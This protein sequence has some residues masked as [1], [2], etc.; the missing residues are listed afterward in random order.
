MPYLESDS[1]NK[2]FFQEKGEGETILMIHG[3]AFDSS[4]WRKQIDYLSR[5]F[6]VIA[7]DL[8]GHG[9]SQYR[10]G[11][12]ITKELL[13]LINKLKY[14]NL[15]IIGHSFGGVLALKL[16]L[17]SP[18]LI[19]R[20]ILVNTS[21]KFRNTNGLQ[22]GLDEQD[23]YKMKKFLEKEYPKILLVFYRWLFTEEERKSSNF[24]DVWRE[25][26]NKD[27]WPQKEALSFMLSMIEQEDLVD[28]LDNMEIPT[29]TTY[30]THDPICSTRAAE[31]MKQRIKNSTLKC[32]QQS[33]HLPFL[34]HAED[35]N[36]TIGNFL[37]NSNEY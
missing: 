2:L 30:G 19:K 24:K 22:L 28:K 10:E 32:F 12:D 3:W 21:L 29:L 17:E 15:T 9:H 11:L 20:I 14:K 34:M 6:K 33:G 7:L 35:F 23:I 18:G 26:S 13:S 25:I 27:T 16:A 5:S 4:V 37:T 31:N 36:K 8:P 1:G